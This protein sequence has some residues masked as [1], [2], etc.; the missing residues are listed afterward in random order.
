MSSIRATETKPE[1]E[2]RKFLFSKGFRFRK[3]SKLLPG[4]PD[5]VLPKYKTVIFVN[6]CFWHG[7]KNCDAAS[8]PKSNKKYWKTKIATNIIRDRR[9]QSELQ[10]LGWNVHVVWECQIT[11][12]RLQNLTIK[13]LEFGKRIQQSQFTSLE[14]LYQR[15]L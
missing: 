5:I 9:K 1:I 3:N 10:K 2:V 13:I 8:I 12:R 4:R 14:T 6:G 7:H 15:T 11:D